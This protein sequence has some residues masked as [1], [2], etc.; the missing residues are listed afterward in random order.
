[1]S[2][3]LAR[4]KVIETENIFCNTPEMEVPKVPEVPFD[5]FG[6][7]TQGQIEK[8]I[9]LIR[10]WLF[11]IGEPKEDHYLVIDK[12]KR[13]PDAMAYF[14]KLATVTGATPATDKPVFVPTVASV[15]VTK[16]KSGKVE[17][18]EDA[19]LQERRNRV[20]AVLAANPNT[21]R[22]YSV[23]A[24][25]DPRHVIV[26]IAIRNVASFEITISKSKWDAFLFLELIERGGVH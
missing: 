16:Q 21:Q 7:S 3:Y 18:L 15:T 10:S 9:L 12:S 13:D 2:G 19:S 24:E 11:Q 6:T 23:D 26:T 20:L 8:N 22:A 17:S 14:L 5:T 1:M 25:A 4:L